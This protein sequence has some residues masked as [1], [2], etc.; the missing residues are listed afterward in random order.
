MHLILSGGAAFAVPGIPEG[1]L[2]GKILLFQT[3]EVG[4]NLL[5]G[6]GEGQWLVR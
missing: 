1:Q 6:L 4:G 2:L 3:H 5:G